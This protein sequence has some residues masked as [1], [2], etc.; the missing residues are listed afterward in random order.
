MIMSTSISL[1]IYKMKKIISKFVYSTLQMTV[2]TELERILYAGLWH[3]YAEYL[4]CVELEWVD[5]VKRRN[6]FT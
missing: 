2:V 4:I 5:M 6:V 3:K 1:N